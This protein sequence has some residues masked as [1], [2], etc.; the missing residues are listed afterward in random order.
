MAAGQTYKPTARDHSIMATASTAEKGFGLSIL[1]V[2]VA[3]LG[4]LG[5]LLGAEDQLI[6]A[7]GFAVAIVAGSLSIAVRHVF[8]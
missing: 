8:D 4:A 2:V 3:L 6:A 5:M 1:F 7:T